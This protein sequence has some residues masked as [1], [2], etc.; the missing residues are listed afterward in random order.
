MSEEKE[1]VKIH[2]KIER[3]L[4]EKLWEITKKEYVVPIKKFHL[5][6]NKII[7]MGIAKYKEIE[8]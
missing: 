5:I 3:D 1:Y 6:V 4:Y 2:V 8:G 7:K